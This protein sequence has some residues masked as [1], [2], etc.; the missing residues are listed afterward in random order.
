M[1]GQHSL[2][3]SSENSDFSIDEKDKGHSL[4]DIKKQS[5]KVKEGGQDSSF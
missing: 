3:L 1:V 5:K 2:L 4:I